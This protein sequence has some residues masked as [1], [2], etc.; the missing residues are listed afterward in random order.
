MIRYAIQLA[1]L[2]EMIRAAK[3]QSAWF[4]KAKAALADL[5][6]SPKSSDFPPLWSKIKQVYITLQCSKC[7][8]CEKSL[9]GKIEQDVEHFRP[10]AEVRPWKLTERLARA[11]VV[12]AQSSDAAPEPGYARLAYHPFNYAMACKYCNS[13]LKKNYF[14]VAGPRQSGGTNPA[15][16]RKER[17]YLIYPLGDHDQDP[18]DL[19]EFDGLSPVPKQPA[20]FGRHRALVVIELF[21]LD[22]PVK[23]R[24]LF[25]GRAYLLRLLFLELEG[26]RNAA[27]PAEKQKHQ[28]AV[29]SLT[30]D[31]CPFAN[32]MRSFVRLYHSDRTKAT[33]YA[34]EC[35]KF[36]NSKS[37]GLPAR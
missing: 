25:K 13:T 24:I 35:L 8:F 26:R 15:R 11:G 7:C 36:L 32:C 3:N 19:I 22:S 6:I 23:R 28:A 31:A 37:L 4:K 12:L 2:K 10:K 20:G 1:R 21:H 33:G 9:E 27:T 18:E 30:S 29:A 16:M 17:A 34:D 5:P 14:P